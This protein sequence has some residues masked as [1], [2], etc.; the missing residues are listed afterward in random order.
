LC[1]ALHCVGRQGLGS[2]TQ[3]SLTSG[4]LTPKEQ[5]GGKFVMLAK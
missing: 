1:S 3:G 2:G 5:N 4:F